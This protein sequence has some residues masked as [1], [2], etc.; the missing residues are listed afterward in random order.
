MAKSKGKGS[1]LNVKELL[2]KKGEY[3][4][5][6]VAGFGLVVLLFMGVST[7]LGKA[8]PAKIS[9]ELKSKSDGITR[10]ISNPNDETQPD[11]ID[12]LKPN[13][14]VYFDYRR[15][16]PEEFALTWV[17]FDPTGRPDTKRENPRVLGIEEY[18]LDL[19]RGAMPG[20]DIIYVNDGKDAQIGVI[21]TKKLSDQDKE[22]VKG[23]VEKLKTKG[24]SGRKKH[25]E[26]RKAQPMEFG[27]PMG[28]PPGGS[29]PMRPGGPP[30]RGGVGGPPPGMGSA[31]GPP[32]GMGSMYGFG[33]DGSGYDS[34]SQ[35]SETTI[36]YIPLEDLDKA[37][38][39]GKLPAMS[40][41]PLRLAVVNAT[42][43][44][45][46]QVEEVKRAM[47]FTDARQAAPYVQF[48][49]FKVKRRIS[50]VGPDGKPQVLQDWADYDYLA[51]YTELIDARKMS[52]YFE[53]ADPANPDG[54]Y[55]PYF[56]KYED[57]LVMP[58]PELVPE[59]GKY[60][61][62]QLKSIQDTIQKL[63]DASTEKVSPSDLIQRLQKK[64][65]RNSIFTP[66]TAQDTMAADLYGQKMFT[67]PFLDPMKGPG[68]EKK[69]AFDP[70]NPG[71]QLEN[72][73]QP[74]D[75][76]HLLVRFVDCDIRPG[77][78]YEYQIQVWMWN[79]N[80]SP[81][82]EAEKYVA[83]PIHA[84]KPILY[85][86]WVPLDKVL[87]VPTEDFLY[88]L[89]PA[90]YR[91]E[92]ARDYK[93]QSDLLRRLQAK[94][95]QAVVEAVKWMEEVRLEN[96]KHEPIGGWVVADMPVSRG[97]YIGK[98]T[99]VKLPL[100]S[101][102]SHQYVFRDLPAA[103]FKGK[104]KEQPKGWLVDFSSRA[105]LVDF[106]G[107]K[108]STRA[109][110]RTIT[111]EVGTEMLIA[112]PDGQLGVHRSI[113]D[114]ADPNRQKLTKGWNDWLKA[115]S[116]RRDAATGGPDNKYERKDMPP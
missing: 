83:N 57:A 103:V 6:G 33:S 90:T 74:I 88:A 21:V 29:F 10:A 76:D 13:S 108:V 69:G 32:P 51:K 28:F 94:D 65:T 115:V 61:T 12:L 53:G 34:A 4:A 89:D 25:E 35:R 85:G 100:W 59:L 18:T 48:D 46:R 43:P 84:R 82:K 102:E 104:D 101:S 60:P 98:K 97:D 87:T 55:L 16:K 58:L 14:N 3:I 15:V 40:V 64:G 20:Y 30:P 72:Q 105:V 86:P 114:A 81:N 2:L 31:G 54:A 24:R 112:R 95:N 8:D 44:L 56:Y 79:P 52:D 42:F 62:L 68:P 50:R 47:R 96:G 107:G 9:N 38:G 11:P 91:E 19:V 49:G 71:G 5:L 7:G 73:Q 26:V 99:F 70:K 78:S 106:E 113:E 17:Q 75:I 67:S 27:G 111:E 77:L 45:K 93:G 80:Y 116:E 109:N 1:K 92:I 63:K 41:I 39:E 37:I 110:G 23:V 22:K 36:A 66:K